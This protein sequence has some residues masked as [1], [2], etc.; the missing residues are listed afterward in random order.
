MANT[1]K[2][3]TKKKTGSRI[4]S[5]A[6]KEAQG[7]SARSRYQAEIQEKAQRRRQFWALMLFAFGL[8]NIGVTYIK[9]ENLWQ[10]LH[11]I[12]FGLISWCAY[13][14]AP[15]MLAVAVLL[16]LG[17][18]HSAPVTRVVQVGV[19]LLLL[20][21]TAQLFSETPIPEG[22]FTEV[23][24]K[25]YQNGLD[26]N[27]GGVV[28]LIVAAPLMWL[29]QTPAR[30]TVLV[31]LFV[32]LML[33]TG[34]TIADLMRTAYK[35]V[36]KLE[37]SYAGRIGERGAQQGCSGEAESVAGVRTGKFAYDID[38]DDEPPKQA[39]EQP[40]QAAR[41]REA[42]SAGSAARQPAG[43][44][45]AARESRPDAGE[46]PFEPDTPASLRAARGT[47]SARDR[48]LNAGG[49]DLT[50]AWS[51]TPEAERE[52]AEPRRASQSYPRPVS[53]DGL[54]IRPEPQTEPVYTPDK[55]EE[56]E[57]ARSAA[58]LD[59]LV[60]RAV[61]SDSRAFSRDG[62][63]RVTGAPQP[64]AAPQ[65]PSEN[66]V[67]EGESAAEA[68]KEEAEEL[69]SAKKREVP[70]YIFPPLE[71]LPEQE[72]PRDEDVSEELKS[73]AANLVDTLNSF[74]VQTRI[75]NISRGP[76]VTRYE[77]QPSAG[78]KISRITGL[79]DDIALNLAAA[80]VRIEAPIPNKAAVGIEVPNKVRSGVSLRE[81]IDSDAFR[82]AQSKLTVA[83]GLD[84][85]GRAITAD[86]AKM[87][88][89][90]IAGSTGSG[91]SVCMNSFIVSLIYKASPEEVR[92]IMIDPKVVE[93]NKYN[94]LPH[95]LIPVVTD[96]RKAAGA[97]GWAVGEMMNRYKLFADNGVN[98]IKSYNRLAGDTPGMT[99]IPQVV[100]II[101]EL[102]DLMMAAPNEV[103]DYICRLAQMARAA[104]MHL[105]IATQRPSVNV[106][107]GVI[108]ANIP[109][110]IALM[111][112][113]YVDSRTILD[114]GGAEKLLG[115][116]DMLFHPAGSPKPTRIQGCFVSDEDVKKIVKLVSS[117]QEAEYDDEVIDEIEHSAVV[118]K[119]AKNGKGDGGGFED[120]D[121]MLPAAIECVIEMGQ[122]STSMLQRKLKLGYSRAGRLMDEMEQRGIVGPFEGSKARAILITRQQWLEMKSNMG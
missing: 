108:K 115:N 93:F 79:A 81:I 3:A 35:P 33:I 10:S 110:R 61:I 51:G 92:L 80:G 60:S 75:I 114:A 113:S 112:S 53:S 19:F 46:P 57:D 106:I 103:E 13:A 104:G 14:V 68:E 121:P 99:R 47:Q 54:Y 102:S 25:V 76:T 59:E 95:L 73:N 90:L 74:G 120:E 45:R 55:P 105:V 107:T 5:T 9:G 20:C 72:Q 69:E 63:F 97:L 29:G 89:L 49:D 31:L 22:R 32:M 24:S 34:L 42:S 111:L 65:E 38:L 37:E 36:K 66:G 30:V 94:G 4:A 11:N 88:H 26:L 2:S 118:E 101:D 83:V 18:I 8:L 117:R 17:R 62:R 116:G 50:D 64:A 87:P 122:A 56:D 48:L 96:P 100:I 67:A 119:G 52:A 23:I 27:G 6:K 21:A 39:Q 71:M 86:L 44:Q 91:K 41:P 43:E 15:S 7:G 84:I 78:V 70:A 82:N 28:S 98:D 58:E 109:S 40:A 85:T 77:L 12:Q 16:S 1:R